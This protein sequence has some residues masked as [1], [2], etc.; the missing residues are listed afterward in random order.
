MAEKGENELN[1]SLILGF[2]VVFGVM[3]LACA[4]TVFSDGRRYKRLHRIAMVDSEYDLA[5][6]PKQWIVAD[7][8]G[9]LERAST[10][11]KV[12]YHTIQNSCTVRDSC[13]FSELSDIQRQLQ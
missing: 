12:I 4:F 2:F 9:W 13:T 11:L 6:N 7:L 3:A 1:D 5:I 8:D 10:G